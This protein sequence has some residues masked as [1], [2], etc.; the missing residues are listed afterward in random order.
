MI[1][2]RLLKGFLVSGGTDLDSHTDVV[3][4]ELLKLESEFVT[5]ADVSVDLK[6]CFVEVSVVATAKSFDEAV[7]IADSAI[8]TA[9]HAAGGSTPRWHAVKYSP[10]RSNADLIS[11]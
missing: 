2:V 6:E 3:M 10:Q 7:E 11:A 9:I 5:D 8:R 1:H 4:E